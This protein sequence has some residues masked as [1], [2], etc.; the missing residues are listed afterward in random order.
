MT[1]CIAAIAEE[2]CNIDSVDVIRLV[3]VATQ[4]EFGNVTFGQKFLRIQETNGK[5]ILHN[6]KTQ[7]GPK[8]YCTRNIV[9]RT[10]YFLQCFDLRQM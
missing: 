3:L 7:V 9:P 4:V 2:C 5:H 8:T 10:G 6:M 1:G